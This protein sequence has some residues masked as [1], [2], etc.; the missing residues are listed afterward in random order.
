MAEIQD[1]VDWGELLLLLLEWQH[2][3]IAVVFFSDLIS[4][5]LD[6]ISFSNNCCLSLVSGS[7]LVWLVS[8]LL[9]AFF[10]LL[11]LLQASTFEGNHDATG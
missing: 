8:E 9:L 2:L 7:A 6:S 4:I 11:L 1:E 3:G 5:F 10:Y